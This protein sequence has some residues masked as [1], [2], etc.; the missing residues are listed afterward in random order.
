VSIFRIGRDGTRNAFV[1][2]LVN[3]T[4]LAF[5]RE[6]VLHVSS[7]FEGIVYRVDADGH[8]EVA[9]TDLGIA[10]GLAFGPDGALYVGDR[11]GTILR[12][13]S[14]GKA[15]PFA[16]LPPSVAAFHLAFGRDDALY[17]TAPSLRTYDDVYRIDEAGQVTV[18]A[19]GFGRPQ[20]IAF[21]AAGRLH[22]AEALAGAGGLFR[23]D[24]AGGAERVVAAP[25]LVG[26]AFDG[27]DALVVATGDTVFR[28]DP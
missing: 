4:S 18:A 11:T 22:V 17:V 3:A 10:C 13:G 28:F 27:N 23:V 1:S 5:D 16:T 2:G 9:A 20:G 24:Q 12:V 14:A 15:V 19:T 7:R 25:S 6:G 8:A 21:D 26:V